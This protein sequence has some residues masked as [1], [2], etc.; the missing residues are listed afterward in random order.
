MRQLTRSRSVPHIH[1]KALSSSTDCSLLQVL[2]KVAQGTLAPTDAVQVCQQLEY[3]AI[4]EYAKIDTKR[5]S[6]TGFPEVIYGEGKTLEQVAEICMAMSAK[7]ET[8]V[9]ATRITPE[10][11]T[12]IQALLPD[13]REYPCHA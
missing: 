2:E 12:A 7:S 8:N 11:A 4:G 5:L 3:D 1:I 6:R 10:A 13:V 9:M